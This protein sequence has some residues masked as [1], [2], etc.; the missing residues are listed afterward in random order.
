MTTTITINEEVWDRLNH[1]VAPMTLCYQCGV[2]TAICPLAATGKSPPVRKLVRSAQSGMINGFDDTWLCTT[3]K[4]CEFTCPR[5]VPIVDV[6]HALRTIAFSD[7]KAPPKLEE[8]LWK[9]YESGNP[10]GEPKTSRSK[11]TEGMGIKDALEGV[12]VLLYTGCAS[13]YDPRLQKIGKATASILKAAGVNFGV[14]KTE[15]KCCGDAVY[16]TGED[17]YLEE[18]VAGNIATFS[19]TKASVIVSISPHCFNM[20]K[21]VYPKYGGD[22]RAVHYTEFVSDLLDS[23]KLELAQTL[24]GEVTYH[25]PCYL[26]RYHGIQEPPRKLLENIKGLKLV[27]MPNSKDNTLC[28]GGGGG[29]VFQESEGER[30]SNIRVREAAETGAQ[31]LATS[32]PYCIQNFE[33]SVKT[34]KKNL[35]VSDVAELIATAL[36]SK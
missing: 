9:I 25:D 19:K 13:S 24:E 22:F 6:M 15:E 28:C 20:F 8:V 3:C 17:S 23:G 2:C 26:S 21:T 5:G 27:E 7:H 31:T 29:R 35:A 14:L 33:D 36:R 12:D 16:Q 10:W 11:W 18:L 30:L 1:A 34:E 4:L 32:C